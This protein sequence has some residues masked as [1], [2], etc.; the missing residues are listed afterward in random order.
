MCCDSK[1]LSKDFLSLLDSFD[2]VQWVSGP[3]HV[4]GPTLDLGMSML[5]IKIVDAGMSAHTVLCV[6]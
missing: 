4:Q 3:T 2:F 1:P 6:I 5:D